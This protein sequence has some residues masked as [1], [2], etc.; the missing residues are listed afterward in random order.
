M[1]TFPESLKRFD[2]KLIVGLTNRWNKRDA[3]R[4]EK[5]RKKSFYFLSP[6]ATGVSGCGLDFAALRALSKLSKTF[7]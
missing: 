7:R 5:C 2:Q 6:T 3:Q 4:Q 1:T